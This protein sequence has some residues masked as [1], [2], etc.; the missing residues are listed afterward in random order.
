VSP[1]FLYKP[2]ADAPFGE[3]RTRT[4]NALWKAVLRSMGPAFAAKIPLQESADHSKMCD[5]VR[6][7]AA[8]PTGDFHRWKA[9]ITG[10]G[11][12]GGADAS[13]PER[14]RSDC[15]AVLEAGLIFMAQVES[16]LDDEDRSRGHEEE[17]GEGYEEKVEEEGSAISRWHDGLEEESIDAVIKGR[18]DRLAAEAREVLGQRHGDGCF[19]NPVEEADVRSESE[20]ASERDAQT[21][22]S[23]P[24]EEAGD[25]S[26]E[27]VD[28]CEVVAALNEVLFS[29]HAFRASRDLGLFPADPRDFL[30]GETLAVEHGDA[31]M[32]ALVYVA[33]AARLGLGLQCL[34]SG[35]QRLLRSSAD[36]DRGL[37]N[38]SGRRCQTRNVWPLKRVDTQVTGRVKSE[39]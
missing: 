22:T 28:A 30:L 35:G 32:L 39:S 36:E 2:P 17:E 19:R 7:Q 25:R 13:D 33:V 31:A 9:I 34:P 10:E 15:G 3:L 8:D 21:H 4:S 26:E 16:K 18:L 29:R 11:G 23:N 12:G 6:R 38:P 14:A 27:C 1:E 37:R 5:F 24:V 20:H